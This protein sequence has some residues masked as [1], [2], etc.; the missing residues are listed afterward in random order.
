MA[1]CEQPAVSV[2]LAKCE[3][4]A[5]SVVMSVVEAFEEMTTLLPLSGRDILAALFS[6]SD[7]SKLSATCSCSNN[8][9]PVTYIYGGLDSHGAQQFED[10][11]KVHKDELATAHVM[12]FTIIEI[13]CL[14]VKMD[15]ET[16]YD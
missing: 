11:K 9:E 15:K 1:K 2:S 7:M 6:Q 13:S 12:E 3:K 16:V 8:V 14:V 10:E 5:V 4:S